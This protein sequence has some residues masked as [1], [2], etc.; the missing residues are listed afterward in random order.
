[1]GGG[2]AWPPP[3]PVPPR[4]RRCTEA[5]EWGRLEVRKGVWAAL[6]TCA[7]GA[8]APRPGPGRWGPS[9][10][11]Q[12]RLR[13]RLLGSAQPSPT[14]QGGSASCPACAHLAAF[15]RVPFVP[16]ALLGRCQRPKQGAWFV[17]EIG[18]KCF[19]PNQAPRAQQSLKILLWARGVASWHLTLAL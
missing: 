19:I 15:C 17:W 18:Q 11:T 14:A 5:G 6:R 9:P 3:Q 2:E 7:A 1:M 8:S 16:I 4:F 13:D 10:P 12:G